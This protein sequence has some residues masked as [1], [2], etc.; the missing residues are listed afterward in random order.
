MFSRRVNVEIDDCFRSA[1]DGSIKLVSTASSDEHFFMKDLQ[2][3][4]GLTSSRGNMPLMMLVVKLTMY[5]GGYCLLRNSL[6]TQCAQ[7][8]FGLKQYFLHRKCK[9]N[10]MSKSSMT[11]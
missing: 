9:T 6:I 11:S 2:W 8:S 7:K 1:W 4:V 5:L 3:K 10:V